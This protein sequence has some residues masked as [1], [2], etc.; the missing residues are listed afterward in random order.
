MRG[1]ADAALM[2]GAAIL[3]IAALV[4]FYWAC[5]GQCGLR[6]SIPEKDGRPLFAPSRGGIVAAGLLIATLGL[7]YAAIASG[8]LAHALPPL[9]VCAAV[10]LVG[11]IFVARGIGDFR[12]VGLFNRGGDTGFARADRLYYSPL[13]IVLGA[14]GL[15]AA[16]HPPPMIG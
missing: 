2:L 1:I 6:L 7:F 14:S 13:C 5:G 10:A 12:H 3:G 15:L 9:F 16:D 11:S 4:H 8:T